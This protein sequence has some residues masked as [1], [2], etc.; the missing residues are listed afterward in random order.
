MSQSDIERGATT[1]GVPVAPSLAPSIENSRVPVERALIDKGV[2]IVCGW[3]IAL[4]LVTGFVAQ[5]L[6]AIIALVTNI[7][8]YGRI[9]TEIGRAHV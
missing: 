7:S 8:F 3:A 4:A 2:L 6:M 1:E 9:S 5:A